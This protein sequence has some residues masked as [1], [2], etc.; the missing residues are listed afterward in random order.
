VRG[1]QLAQ[2]HRVLL[3]QLQVHAVEVGANARHAKATQ[4]AGNQVACSTAAAAAAMECEQRRR[5][6][7][8]QLLS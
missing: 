2:L 5:S 3:V 1:Q 6:G 8:P 7:T 4:P